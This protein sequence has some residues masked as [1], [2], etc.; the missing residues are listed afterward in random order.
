VPGSKLS[1]VIITRMS[2]DNALTVLAAMAAIGVV[3]YGA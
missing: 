3:G 1:V 2:P